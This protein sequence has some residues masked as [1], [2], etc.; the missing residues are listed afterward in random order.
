MTTSRVPI[1]SPI[2]G[3]AMC[4]PGQSYTYTTSPT[5]ASIFP[6]PPSSPPTEGGYCYYHYPYEWTAPAGWSING[7]GNTAFTNETVS[8]VAPAGTP[9][10]S[11]NISV[12]GSIS[13]PGGG[14]WYSTKR[15]FSVQIGSFSQYQVSVSGPGMVCN[16]NSYTYTA[17][18][19]T[20]HQN[21]YSYNWTYP[22]GWTVQNTSNN[23]ITFYLPSYN[24]SYG[25]VRVS[26][27][28]GCGATHLTGIT[29]QPCSYTMSSGD[30][31]IYPNPSSGDLF[32]EYDVEKNQLGEPLDGESQTQKN[33]PAII[34][35]KVDIFDRT[36]KLVGTGK[37]AENKV[38]LDTKG[39]QPG[40][41]FL[42][43]YSGDHVLREQII[44]EN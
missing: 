4:S 15:N 7:G 3:P 13:K 18:V 33:K 40:T 21:G 16:G 19:P 28:N 29:V 34:I 14:F 32:V 31:K 39:L 41:Y 43:I 20:G 22:S 11:Y 10:G 42:H 26:V 27:N 37:S 12:Q 30:F 44:I 6:P 5:L 25:P 23:T 1:P 24:N 9:Q 38:Y 36:E 8:I 2:S 17:N 35:F